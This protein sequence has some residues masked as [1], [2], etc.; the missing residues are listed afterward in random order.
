VRA[1]ARSAAGQA[2]AE[3]VA[4][5]AVVA[6]VLTGALALAAFPALTPAVS[7]TIRHGI[8]IV[9]GGICTSREARAAGMEPCLVHSRGDREQVAVSA[10]LVRLGRDDELLVERRSDGTAAVSF[11]DGRRAGFEAALGAELKWGQEIEV[12]AGVQ[13]NSGRTWEFGTA[14]AAG[15]F[16][17][18]WAHEETL[19]GEVRSLPRKLCPFCHAR[20]KPPPPQ[21]TYREL[22]AYGE[23]R[24]DIDLPGRMHAR[25]APGVRVEGELG[26]VIGRRVSGT[27]RT[28]YA[29]LNASAAGR[30]GAVLGS[31]EL[32][33]HGDAALEITFAGDR[34]V[35]LRVRAA[36]ALR[37]QLDLLGAT[38]SL[39]D[40]AAKLRSATGVADHGQGNG[41]GVETQ[42]SLDLTD[43]R[44]RRA[45]L[46][47]LGMLEP[48]VSP[49]DW[50]DR[51]R[52]LAGRLDADGSVDVGVYRVGVSSEH[53]VDAS[54]ALGLKLGGEYRREAE[55]RELVRAWS[56]R[57]GG[58]LGE[59][60]DCVS[61]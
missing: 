42:V 43:E 36:A 49:G 10:L 24:D 26:A 55:A 11:I 23:F 19:T 16:V 15:R 34:P 37:D 13:F 12:G 1:R 21:A 27:H 58:T 46:D 31:V 7:S 30:L 50:D 51:I 38:T 54:A 61:A 39:E 56:L 6:M 57:H 35:E 5:L 59:R 14:A 9:A 8:C 20:P 4:L 44:N 52:A 41:L 17:H 3:Y 47:F 40:L 60:E 2:S 48:G 32:A 25:A 18:R 28:L 29:R 45:A 33:R 22:G 53:D